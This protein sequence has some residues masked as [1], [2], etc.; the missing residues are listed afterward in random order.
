MECNLSYERDHSRG[1]QGK[2][3]GGCHELERSMRKN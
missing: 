3:K 1:I 2:I